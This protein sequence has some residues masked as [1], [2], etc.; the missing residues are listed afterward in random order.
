MNIRKTVD[1]SPHPHRYFLSQLSL[2]N[3]R[4]TA[5]LLDVDMKRVEFIGDRYGYTGTSSPFLALHHAAERKS[6]RHGDT[7]VFWSIGTGVETC[8]LLWKL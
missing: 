7:V 6:V 8:S 5:E 1:K 4:S 3:L 2:K